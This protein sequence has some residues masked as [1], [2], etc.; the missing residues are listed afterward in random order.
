MALTTFSTLFGTLWN[1]PYLMDRETGLF[2]I[3]FLTEWEE[4]F[5]NGSIHRMERVCTTAYGMKGSK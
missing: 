5:Q 1:L 3:L 4:T 2:I